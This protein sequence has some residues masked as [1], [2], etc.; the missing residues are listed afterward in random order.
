[1]LRLTPC[2]IS[3]VKNCISADA[4]ASQG[5]PGLYA[6]VDMQRHRPGLPC[7][8]Q[9]RYEGSHVLPRLTHT[10]VIVDGQD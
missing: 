5:G 2:S 1:M 10:T 8:D 9:Q 7:P 4:V 6:M 3:M